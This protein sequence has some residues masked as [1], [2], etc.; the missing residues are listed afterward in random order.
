[1]NTITDFA[2]K[3]LVEYLHDGDRVLIL[4]D[5][6]GMGDCVMFLPL[7]ERLKTMY[8]KVRFSLKCNK[9]QEIFNDILDEEFDFTF[10]I[11]F[12]E[13][14]NKVFGRRVIGMS[15]PEICAKMELGIPFDKDIEFTWKPKT[16][17]DSGIVVPERAIGVAFQVT[18]NPNKSVP[19]S[20]AKFV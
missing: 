15:K 7:Y 20:S 4:F 18:S 10:S 17:V 1:M 9:G 19:E 14:N 12:Y 3:R 2:G 6:H 16:I 11:T 8:P 13:F 5:W